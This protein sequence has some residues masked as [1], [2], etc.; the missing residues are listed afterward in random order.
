[1]S[2]GSQKED[3]KNITISPGE[4]HRLG[5]S[6]HWQPWQCSQNLHGPS[7]VPYCNDSW[8][9]CSSNGDRQKDKSA[10]NSSTKMS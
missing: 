2:N 10:Q 5:V 4:F 9:E 6:T 3:K 7:W 1:V 8:S